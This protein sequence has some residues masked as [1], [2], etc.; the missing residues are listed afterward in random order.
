M[1]SIW[2]NHA[3]EKTDKGSIQIFIAIARAASRNERPLYALFRF[4]SE[5]FIGDHCC[6]CSASRQKAEVEI[7]APIWVEFLVP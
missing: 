3:N 1:I 7:L 6:S 5:G 2:A 4:V